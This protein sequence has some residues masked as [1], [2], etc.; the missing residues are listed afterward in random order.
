VI[1]ERALH[2]NPELRTGGLGCWKGH[3][4]PR[5]VAAAMLEI[6]DVAPGAER[7]FQRAVQ[8]HAGSG[9]LHLHLH[10]ARPEDLGVGDRCVREIHIECLRPVLSERA[11]Q[12]AHGLRGQVPGV[13]E[14]LSHEL[15]IATLRAEPESSAL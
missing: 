9:I 4:L 6:G 2:T 10:V 12:D 11:V 14:H 8:H 13:V 5:E 7:L 3:V 15:A 1:V